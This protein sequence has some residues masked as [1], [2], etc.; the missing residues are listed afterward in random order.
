MKRARVRSQPSRRPTRGEM[1]AEVQLLRDSKQYKAAYDLLA[2]AT[3]QS[4]VRSGLRPGD[5]SRL[6]HLEEMERLLRSV[7]AGKPEYQRL[8]RAG[9]LAE[10]NTRLPEAKQLILKA[11]GTRPAALS[12]PQPG[13]G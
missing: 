13:L 10:R 9:L 8:Q 7:V 11:L 6:G 4:A 3:A 12:S 2:E 5:D 1:T